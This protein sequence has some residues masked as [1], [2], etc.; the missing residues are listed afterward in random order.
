MRRNCAKEFTAKVISSKAN[1]KPSKAKN[2][3]CNK[4]KKKCKYMQ[5]EN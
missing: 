4:E 1:A 2:K 5:C 3:K